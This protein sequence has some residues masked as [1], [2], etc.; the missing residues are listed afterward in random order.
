MSLAPGSQTSSHRHVPGDVVLHHQSVVCD[1]KHQ[2]HS[3]SLPETLMFSP[4][5][6]ELE[7][8]FSQT[9]RGHVCTL[10]PDR[11]ADSEA[12]STTYHEPSLPGPQVITPKERFHLYLPLKS[13]IDPARGER[14][15]SLCNA[16]SLGQIPTAATASRSPFFR[17]LLDTCLLTY[18]T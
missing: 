9:T 3:E 2:R 4:T 16:L 5:N 12:V 1:K 15:P 10:G 11:A 18:P 7:S 8:V 14:D 17:P 6:N 13:N